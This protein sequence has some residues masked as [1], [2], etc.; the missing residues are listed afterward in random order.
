VHLLVVNNMDFRMHGATIKIN[1]VVVCYVNS[2]TALG[3]LIFI[4]M[5]SDCVITVVKFLYNCV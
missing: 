3:P 2:S 4:R 1:R 5:L